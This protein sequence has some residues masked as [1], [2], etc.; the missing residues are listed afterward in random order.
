LTTAD[1]TLSFAHGSTGA[2]LFIPVHRACA[3]ELKV[4]AAAG[5]AAGSGS[6]HY[7][8]CGTISTDQQPVRLLR[9]QPRFFKL[10]R[11]GG[12][13]RH[14]AEYHDTV[15]DWLLITNR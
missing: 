2:S 10:Y 14:R 3:I 12:T 9:G 5:N 6:K 8:P 7:G 4:Q 15:S 1:E 13:R 11:A